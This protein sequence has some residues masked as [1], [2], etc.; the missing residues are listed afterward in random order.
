[1]HVNA[2]AAALIVFHRMAPSTR[3]AERKTSGTCRHSYACSSTRRWRQ[4]F[5]VPV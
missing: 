5:L 1:M 2:A 4:Q 3:F